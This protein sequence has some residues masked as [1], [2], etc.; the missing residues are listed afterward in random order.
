MSDPEEHNQTRCKGFPVRASVGHRQLTCR[1]GV[2]VGGEVRAKQG[3]KHREL[4]PEDRIVVIE[5]QL[6]ARRSVPLVL[7]RQSKEDC[8]MVLLEARLPYKECPLLFAQAFGSIWTQ[9]SA[10]QRS[11][12]RPVRH[13][14]SFV[15]TRER[16]M[17]AGTTAHASIWTYWQAS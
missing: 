14:R 17:V 8:Y 3:D 13:G 9:T 11:R 16:L 4:L 12:N 10:D 7:S 15:D 1:A 2:W 6:S 5:R